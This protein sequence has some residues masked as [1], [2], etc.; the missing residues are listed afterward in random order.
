MPLF[1]FQFQVLAESDE[2]T[3]WFISELGQLGRDVPGG[4]FCQ[5]GFLGLQKFWDPSLTR[6]LRF[7]DLHLSFPTNLH[8]QMIRMSNPLPDGFTAELGGFWEGSSGKTLIK[9][10]DLRL[11]KLG[12]PCLT[13]APRLRYLGISIKF[14]L[15]L[16][17]LLTFVFLLGRLYLETA[18]ARAWVVGCVGELLWRGKCSIGGTLSW[19]HCLVAQKSRRLSPPRAPRINALAFLRFW[20]PWTHLATSWVWLIWCLH[21][22]AHRIVGSERERSYEGGFDKILS[23][24][25]PYAWAPLAC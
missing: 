1:D 15:F 2:L 3:E 12:R 11:L 23:F 20:P 6:A 4:I 17:I 9:K 8:V 7:P 24:G 14:Q 21:W 16:I 13:G 5:K 22:I 18:I 10:V 19:F 25:P